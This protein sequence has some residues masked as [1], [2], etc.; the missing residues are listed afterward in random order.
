VPLTN[1][2]EVV[3][4]MERIL[5]DLVEDQDLLNRLGLQAMSYARECLTWEAKAQSVTRIMH[6]VMGQASRPDLPPPKVLEL[7][8]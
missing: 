4:E 2:S 1:E 8:A 5:G 7:A 6:W 3:S